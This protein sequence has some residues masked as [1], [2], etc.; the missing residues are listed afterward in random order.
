M[1]SKKI[2]L[3]NK[4]AFSMV[5][6]IFV[7]VMM[8]TLSSLILGLV[9]KTVKA[10]TQQYQKEQAILLAKSY[11]ELAILYVINYPRTTDCLKSIN[12]HFGPASPNGYEIQSTIK[13][14]GKASEVV[15][16][17]TETLA[18]L[19][20]TSGFDESMS[21]VVDTYVR[22]IGYND[23]QERNSTYFKRTLQKL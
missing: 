20:G 13:Y 8:A 7:I 14:I 16:C 11:T 5:T 1:Q 6:A 21:I 15:N 19:N 3:K 22:Y 23:I 17:N 18:A 9:N 12:S 4:K 10:T 2:Y